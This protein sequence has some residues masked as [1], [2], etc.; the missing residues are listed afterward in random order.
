MHEN[1]RKLQEKRAE[2]EAFPKNTTIKF[3]TTAGPVNISFRGYWDQ[4]P[5]IKIKQY[6]FTKSN[7]ADLSE[8][9]QLACMEFFINNNPL[10]SLDFIPVGEKIEIDLIADPR[11]NINA[12]FCDKTNQNYYDAS[13]SLD[14]LLLA[15]TIYD[16]LREN[17]PFISSD[18]IQE[19]QKRVYNTQDRITKIIDTSAPIQKALLSMKRDALKLFASQPASSIQNDDLRESFPFEDFDSVIW[20]S[21]YY[22]AWLD[23]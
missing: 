16:N 21:P 4:Q 23:A 5:D 2:I 14:S 7:Y 20:G 15:K 19:I 10:Y 17:Y 9:N 18:L 8:N 13:I 12:K 3:K 1:Y 22:K 6:N 11:Y